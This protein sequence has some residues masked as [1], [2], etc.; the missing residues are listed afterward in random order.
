LM[1]KIYT[2]PQFISQYFGRI[3]P[4]LYHDLGYALSL[5]LARMGIKNSAGKFYLD[6]K[7]E[8]AL[9]SVLRCLEFIAEGEIIGWRSK[10]MTKA[11]VSQLLAPFLGHR[12]LTIFAIFCP[13]YKK[14]IGSFGFRTDGVGETTRLGL[15]NLA[16]LYNCAV[17]NNIPLNKPLGLFFDVAVENHQ[18]VV[19]NNGLSD[20]NINFENLKKEATKLSFPFIFQKI[21]KIP[22]LFEKIGYQGIICGPLP[23][24]RASYSRILERGRKF[25]QL[26]GWTEKEVV[27]RT[28]VIARSEYL[29]GKWLRKE[30][31]P[32]ILV[33]T[34]TMLE[35]GEI[36][37]GRQLATNPFPAYFP[38][39]D[40]EIATIITP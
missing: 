25:Y 13:S 39:K 4:V 14:G 24:S 22:E 5:C 19:K 40:E 23:I 30:I 28:K 10:Q 21:S 31:M 20:L 16:D 32:A 27:F 34:P 9:A 12:K 38:R 2:T 17:K 3:S 35:R 29:V 1:K 7:S 15:K 26:F 36:Y 11:L 6:D 18:K 8:K 37:S 33:Y